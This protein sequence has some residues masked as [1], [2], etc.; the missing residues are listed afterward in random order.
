M[1]GAGEPDGPGEPELDPTLGDP[2]LSVYPR[3][4]TAEGPVAVDVEL[5]AGRLAVRVAEPGSTEVRVEIREFGS[6]ES[7]GTGDPAWSFT[8][9]EGLSGL[10]NWVGE[11]IGEYAAGN[12]TAVHDATIEFGADRLRVRSS[13]QLPLRLVPLDVSIRVPADSTLRLRSGGAS[14]EVSGPLGGGD[15]QTGSG[16]VSLESVTGPMELQAGT[17]QVHVGSV[18]ARLRVRTGAGPVAVDGLCESAA[19]TT[20]GGDVTVGSLHGELMARTGN[21]DITIREAHSGSVE[22]TAGSGELRIG[23]PSGVL[24][25]LDLQGAPGRMHSELDIQAQRPEPDAAAEP[26]GTVRLRGRTGGGITLSKAS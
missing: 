26:A 4:Y 7:P 3:E 25:E 20:G 8:G 2:D 19:I 21:G 14:V 22:L 24:A 6:G 23:V 13:K 12:L 5:P 11:R 15:I 1:S 17:G 18:A 10:L 16:R 9:S